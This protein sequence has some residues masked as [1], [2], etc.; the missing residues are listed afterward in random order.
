MRCANESEKCVFDHTRCASKSELRAGV[1]RLKKANEEKHKLLA[2]ITQA[3]TQTNVPNG[4]GDGV[5]IR[6]VVLEELPNDNGSLLP[7]AVPQRA[8]HG[9]AA[10][11]C[12]PCFSLLPS[13]AQ[14]SVSFGKGALGA[15]DQAAASTPFLPT[16]TSLSIH[17][18]DEDVNQL[19]TDTW[20]K[21]G[22]S[23]AY[24]QQLFDAVLTWDYLPF[25]LL[26]RAA[27]LED[28]NSRLSRYCSSTLV[29]ALLALATR[30]MIENGSENVSLPNGW[31]GSKTFF[32]V[33]EELIRAN[34]SLSKLPD[35]QALGILSL[36]QFS[37]G[38]ETKAQELADAFAASITDLC[39]QQS[40][41]VT[42]GDPYLVVRATTYCGAVSLIRML[43]LTTGDIFSP[44]TPKE[45]DLASLDRSPCN[46][47]N[48]SVADRGK[49][50]TD[51]T[52]DT[53]YSTICSLQIVPAKIFQLT[54]WVYKLLATANMPSGEVTWNEVLAIYTKCLDWY[55]S[56]LTVLKDEDSERPFVLFIQ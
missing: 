42:E 9:E 53:H 46:M 18:G 24:V 51:H 22:W 52:L 56:F 26:C 43:R 47:E 5:K 16:P 30:M 19:Q 32:D 20:T 41:H 34:G 12:S 35:I 49:E 38:R 1:T 11:V 29:H 28:Y 39:L 21:T 10:L 15:E 8:W 55:E 3:D 37:C 7:D 44:S 6:Q 48:E 23:V 25:C 54:E 36:Y 40:L 14:R 50:R 13:S 33:A 4:Q 45:A 17:S 31:S 2:A 27:F